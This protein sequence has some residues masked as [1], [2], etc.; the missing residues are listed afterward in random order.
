MDGFIET[1]FYKKNSRETIFQQI[2]ILSFSNIVQ[3]D[4]SLQR[5]LS[6]A[7]SIIIRQLA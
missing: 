5:T 1:V 2:L 6:P 4:V 3:I 7:L